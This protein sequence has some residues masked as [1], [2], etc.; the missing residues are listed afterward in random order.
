MAWMN[1]PIIKIGSSGGEELL[2]KTKANEDGYTSMMN[3]L[4]HTK[5]TR[6]ATF[7]LGR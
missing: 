4:F 1:D 3:L 6:D 5:R 7:H 2:K